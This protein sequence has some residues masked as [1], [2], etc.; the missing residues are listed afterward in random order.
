MTM[1]TDRGVEPVLPQWWTEEIAASWQ[2]QR[3]AAMRSWRRDVDQRIPRDVSIVEHALAFG[4]GARS[5]Y[6]QCT[7]WS[8][9]AG[10]LR[11]DWNRLGNTGPASWGNVASIIEHE[12]RRAAGPGGDAAPTES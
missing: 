2:R 9:V 4:H 3:D 7:T 5:A 11:S 6:S 10:H 8:A 12:W 1:I